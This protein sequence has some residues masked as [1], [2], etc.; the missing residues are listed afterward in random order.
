MKKAVDVQELI[1]DNS[2]TLYTSQKD[3][4]V[5]IEEAAKIE[6]RTLL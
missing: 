2:L 3:N 4:V 1:E 6:E 5:K